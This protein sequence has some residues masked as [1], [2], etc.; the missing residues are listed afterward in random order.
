MRTS[1][2]LGLSFAAILFPFAHGGCSSSS[3]SGAGGGTT[4]GS[5][6]SG[7][8]D[9]CD[10]SVDVS[11]CDTVIAASADD[12]TRVQT[13]LIEAKSNSTVC[14]CPGSFAIKQ[15]L[16]LTVPGVTFRGAGKE[17]GDTVIDFSG[18]EKGASGNDT[19]LVTADHFTIENLT[20]KNTP[21]NGVVVRQ[22]DHPTFRKL[23]VSWDGP[24]KASNGAY[25]IYPA[26]CSHVLVEDCEVFGAS[27]AA[28]YVGQGTGALIRNNKAHDSVL[29]IEL[30]NTTDG[31]AYGNETYN[32]AGGLAVFLLTNLNKKDS[33]RILLHDNKV[34]DNNHENFGD[35]KTIVSAVPPGTGII[36]M[37]ADDVEVRDNT[38]TGNDSAG[39]LVVDYQ[40]LSALVS[41][42]KPDPNTDPDPERIS[43]HDNTFD[44]NGM[45]PSSALQ[46][47]GVMPLE[48]VLWDGISKSGVPESN[49]A[50]FCLGSKGPYPSFRMFAGAHIG[51]KSKQSTDTTPYQCDLP[52]VP[53]QPEPSP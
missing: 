4:T 34:H 36:V 41:G 8:N 40:L 7:G 13:A 16:S 12:T 17:I 28:I 43:V 31:E 24:T 19:M 35:P 46:L 15:Q 21:G 3:S 52:A 47:I 53:A 1:S 51:D 45:A 50:K 9:T 39:V 10:A 33:N 32:N 6:T 49:D 18:A 30:E 22:A 29:G 44:N 25:A 23:H 26:E 14:L 42:A 11:G 20:V 2:W 27:D 48:N 5:T 37:A 38:V